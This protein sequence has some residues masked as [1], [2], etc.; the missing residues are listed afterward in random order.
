MAT[1]TST[2]AE[3]DTVLGEAID[4][5]SRIYE[6]LANGEFPEGLEWGNVGDMAA[7]VKMLR[8]SARGARNRR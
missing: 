8:N 6:R 4:I 5:A 1:G 2:T 7:M 3:Y